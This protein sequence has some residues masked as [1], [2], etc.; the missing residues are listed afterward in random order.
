[1]E[2]YIVQ[3]SNAATDENFYDLLGISRDVTSFDA[4]AKAYGNATAHIRMLSRPSQDAPSTA[5]TM[6]LH[7]SRCISAF[8][9][10]AVD[11]T[12]QAYDFFLEENKRRAEDAAK[13]VPQIGPGAFAH[14]QKLDEP[15]YGPNNTLTA[16]MSRMNA[17]QME[18]CI[19]D[20]FGKLDV[21]LRQADRSLRAE[22]VEKLPRT[23]RQM[24]HDF[25]LDK[26]RRE[27]EVAQS[28]AQREA[29]EHATCVYIQFHRLP[30]TKTGRRQRT[31]ADMIA[32]NTWQ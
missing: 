30:A 13:P 16:R 18:E 28:E 9:T 24:L 12:R 11:K 17:E 7:L 26:K 31:H 14:P 4:L 20:S 22:M 1:M 3:S 10:L 19:K 21:I 32:I 29:A 8:T 6:P 2:P 5:H 23:A 25:A 27:S 15:K